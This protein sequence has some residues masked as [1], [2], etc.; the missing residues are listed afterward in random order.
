MF[1]IDENKNIY[2]IKGDTSHFRMEIA[3]YEM[4]DGD[5]LTLTVRKRYGS[6]VVL[7]GNADQDAWFHI[8]HEMYERV[9]P[10]NYLYDIQLTTGDGEVYTL[11]GPAH[12]TVD[13][14]ITTAIAG[15]SEDAGN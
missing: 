15:G 2:T 5:T 6:E 12:F 11:I 3:P 8:T 4:R 1:K 10:G 13:I 7:T 14:E 9:E